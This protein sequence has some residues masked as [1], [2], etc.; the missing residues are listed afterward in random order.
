MRRQK[1][2]TLIEL[3]VVIAII[4]LLMSI[5]MPALARVREQAMSISCQ[6]NLKQWALVWS[7]YLEDNEGLFP[8][9]VI[10]LPIL[11][12]YIPTSGIEAGG[13][14]SYPRIEL[15]FCPAATELH[16]NFG[17]TATNPYSAWQ[18]GG[19]KGSYGWNPWLQCVMSGNPYDH[20]DKMLWKLYYPKKANNIPILV[21]NNKNQ[22]IVPYHANDPPPFQGANDTVGSTNSE[23]R[24]ACISRH[25]P[26]WIN[27]L[28]CDFTVRKIGLKELW[29]LD[30]HRNWYYGESGPMDYNPPDWANEA[31]WMK[32]FKDYA[33]Y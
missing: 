6:A 13:G 7:F 27:G 3:L 2:F 30:W 18:E 26:G 19:Y 22:N 16:I 4:A 21:D 24:R 31:P 5:L 32:G 25:G 28:F 33:R 8:G 23:I 9:T 10:W 17:G 11:E 12:P 14:A 1:G 15:L 20:Q 29:E